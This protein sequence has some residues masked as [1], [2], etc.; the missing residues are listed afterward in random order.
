MS[1]IIEI[2]ARQQIDERV[3]R[4][5]APR[6]PAPRRRQALASKLRRIADR[7]DN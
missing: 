2:E 1:T 4:A 5:S 6:V 7:L 3:R